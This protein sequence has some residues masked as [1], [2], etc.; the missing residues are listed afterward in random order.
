MLFKNAL[1]QSEKAVCEKVR[2]HGLAY[3]ISEMKTSA[4]LQT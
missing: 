3:D 1:H 4:T 2:R